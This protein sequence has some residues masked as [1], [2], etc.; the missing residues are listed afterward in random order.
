MS[1]TKPQQLAYINKQ[2]AKIEKKEKIAKDLEAAKSK[3][4]N[5]KLKKARGK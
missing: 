1:R 2:I 3:L 4:A 5:L